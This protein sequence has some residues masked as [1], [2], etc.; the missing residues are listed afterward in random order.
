MEINVNGNNDLLHK[1]LH[2][3]NCIINK[4]KTNKTQ[5][6]GSVGTEMKG[7]TN[8]SGRGSSSGTKSEKNDKD[9]ESITSLIPMEFVV[10]EENKSIYRLQHAVIRRMT[11]IVFGTHHFDKLVTFPKQEDVNVWIR[12]KK[13]NLLKPFKNLSDMEPVLEVNADQLVQYQGKDA[14][15]PANDKK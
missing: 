10:K 8:D 2:S 11:L 12:K 5:E 13:T 9:G 4:M 15:S 6:I 7:D 1:I 3:C 14:E